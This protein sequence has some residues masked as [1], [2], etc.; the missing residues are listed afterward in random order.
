MPIGWRKTNHE[1]KL[2]QKKTDPI[3]VYT[4]IMASLLR[5]N[6]VQTLKKAENKLI[7]LKKTMRKTNVHLRVTR[8]TS[9]AGHKTHCCLVGMVTG[10]HA[11]LVYQKSQLRNT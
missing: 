2:H 4:D 5:G 1:K 10:L 3:T 8:K 11:D 9:Q 7:K 6:S